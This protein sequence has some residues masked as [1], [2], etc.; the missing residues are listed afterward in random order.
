MSSLPDF[1]LLVAQLFRLQFKTDFEVAFDFVL[2]LDPFLVLHDDAINDFSEFV[3]E[4]VGIVLLDVVEQGS[5]F[6]L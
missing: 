1:L 2:C 4:A 6:F 5:Y 3:F